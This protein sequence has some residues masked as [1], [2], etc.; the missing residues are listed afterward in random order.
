MTPKARMLTINAAAAVVD[1]LT[2]H[3]IRQLCISGEIPTRMAGK[4][5]LINE[6]H[7]LE[8]IGDM[9]D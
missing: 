9:P 6:K 8:Y 3:R 1:G 4:K 7:L 5:Y 2:K